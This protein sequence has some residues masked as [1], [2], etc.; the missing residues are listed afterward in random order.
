[1]S[2]PLSSGLLIRVLVALEVFGALSAMIGA[3]FALALHGGGVPVEYLANSPFSS[4]VV[5]GLVLGIVV[6]GTQTVAA[7]ALVARRQH[8]LLL[9]AVA[10]FG[11]LIW[12]FVELA[13]IQHYSWLQGV[14]FAHGVLELLL[15]LALLGV[16][17]SVA[18][19]M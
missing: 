16:A 17:P 11:M 9:S 3:V 4:F 7:V 8:A 14:Y 1:M 10:G 19:P 2:R 6:G 12:I 18:T 5:P 15:V 13:V